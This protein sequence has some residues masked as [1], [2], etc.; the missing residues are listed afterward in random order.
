MCGEIKVA[1]D[2]AVSNR[3]RTGLQAYCR[4]CAS[5]H[6]SK[7]R[8]SEASR[9]KQLMDLR[10]A[11]ARRKYGLTVQEWETLRLRPCD[12][13]GSIRSKMCIDHTDN[14]SYHGVLCSQCNTAIGL[15]GYAPSRVMSAAEYLRRTRKDSDG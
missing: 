15:L 7:R 11:T 13:C 14:G 4:S 5:V 6:N 9:S 10:K 8:I 12:I 1:D 3:D 2:F